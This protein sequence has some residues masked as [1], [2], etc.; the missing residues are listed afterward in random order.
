MIRRILYR[1]L[2]AW[3][4]ALA[5]WHGTACAQ[6]A[7][8]QAADDGD[9]TKGEATHI[10][11]N[12]PAP[13]FGGAQF[14][15]DVRLFHGW[16]I[17]RNVFTGHYRLLDENNLRYAWG[18]FDECAA[19]LA[20]IRR[21]YSLPPMK[22]KAVICLHGLGRGPASME[23]M[24]EY[25]RDKGGYTV[26]NVTYPSTRASVAEHAK[27]LAEI[28]EHLDGIEEIHFV[29]HSLGNVVLRHY[30]ADATDEKTGRRPD[31]RIGRIV[32]L[33]PPNQGAELARQFGRH[34]AFEVLLGDSAKELGAD[35]NTFQKELATPAV[36][37]G[38]IAGGKGQADG[39][40]PL[41]HGDDDLVVGVEETKL[42]GASDFLVLPVLHTFMMRDE[43]VQ[44]CTLRFL[45]KGYF[46]TAEKRQPLAKGK[47]KE[48]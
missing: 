23:P 46:L 27:A 9:K 15:A 17:Q 13:T 29:A 44:A 11:F 12:L 21:K 32:M 1:V 14:W 38:I 7:D 4:V 8:H 45:Q 28:L 36:P 10:R 19:R 3:S 5:L 35:W 48:K 18:S 47:G 31:R 43:Q 2:L 40:N 20:E 6:S 41:I 25:L 34:W 37:F 39:R 24:A 22:G 16:H 26:F 42:S 30:L 33:G